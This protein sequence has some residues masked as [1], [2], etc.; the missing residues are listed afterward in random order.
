M[1]WTASIVRDLIVDLTLSQLRSM[2]PSERLHPRD[3]AQ[4]FLSGSS[5]PYLDSLETYQIAFRIA[6]F[7]E[8]HRSGLD[9]RLLH[10]VR[11]DAWV[12]LV[13]E[14]R[15]SF[16]ETLTF[17]T[18]GSTGQPKRVVQRLDYLHRE[19][20]FWADR[21]QDRVR[22]DGTIPRH[23]LFGFVFG[24][25]VP[26][27]L[28]A[29]Y[30]ERRGSLPR[31]LLADSTPGRLLVTVP[32]VAAELVRSAV[33]AGPDLAIVTS[34][35]PL[36]PAVQRALTELGVVLADHV[37][38]STETGG[39]GLR[40]AGEG[41]FELLPFFEFAQ[42]DE[43]LRI[44]DG[45]RA[46]DVQDT[47]EPALPRRFRVQG[48]LDAMVQVGGH[49]VSLSFVRQK[50]EACPDVDVAAVRS[51]TADAG[52]RIK[53]FVVPRTPGCEETIRAF[54]GT[55]LPPEE[56]PYSITFGDALPTTELGKPA[57]W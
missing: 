11:V 56:R 15:A 21:Y 23:H 12:E 35:A 44:L 31:G 41:A 39:I 45:G 26:A 17:Q 48:R 4:D 10:E 49:N 43:S 55:H 42:T 1:D 2:R 33:P 8:L 52:N 37:Y 20:E 38:G 3:L 53:A 25:L 16:D 30:V 57:D 6:D 5:S 32:E 50:I 46:L 29:P 27:R 18:S 14:A 7:F 19:A 47:L 40:R 24:V 13:L 28:D 9:E 51:E 34:T 54:I 36:N 22:V